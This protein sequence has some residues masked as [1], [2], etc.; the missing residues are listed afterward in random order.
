MSVS[1]QSRYRFEGIRFDPERGLEKAGALI[2]LGA[3]ERRLLGVLLEAGGKVVSKESLVESVWRGA[4]VSD[5]SIAR[6][7]FRLRRTLRAAGMGKAVATVYGGGFRI[8][9]K[10]SREPDRVATHPPLSGTHSPA[11]RECVITAREMIGRRGLRDMTSATLAVRRAVR[12]DPGYVDAWVLLALVSQLR[13]NRGQIATPHVGLRRARWASRHALA[14]SP[15]ADGALGVLGWIEA[16][17]DG[18][19]SAGLALLDRALA[20]NDKEWVIYSQRAWALHAARQ[21]EAGLAEFA[22]MMQVNPLSTFATGTYG[23]ALACAGRTGEA[24]ALLDGAIRVMP[25]VDSLYFARSVVAAMTGDL[26]LALA[27]ARRCAELSPDVPNQVCSLACALAATGDRE[28]ARSLL[29]T[30]ND[31]RCRLAPSWEALTLA[32]IG[33]RKAAAQ[34]LERAVRERC[35]WLAFVQYDPRL[36]ALTRDPT[37][38]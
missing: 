17:I 7:V 22:T 12:L 4:V 13:V 6:S 5:A 30:M 20:L 38:R 28:R 24:L 8:A 36:R 18:N 37:R 32:M 11:A 21:P 1:A 31:M 14:V 29:R 16:V 9:V 26:A 19:V 10:V 23:Y 33:D 34:A 25:T 27:D 2:P 15:D 35:S 3:Q